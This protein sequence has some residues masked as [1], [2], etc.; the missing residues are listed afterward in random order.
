MEKEVYKTIVQPKEETLNYLRGWKRP[1]HA[2]ILFETKEW[3]LSHD[4]E[5][6]LGTGLMT[7]NAES[8]P[9]IEHHLDIYLKK[10]FRILD[11]GNFPKFSDQDP[12]RAAKAMHY[13]QGAGINPWDALERA[14]KQ[15]MAS[16]INWSERASA[17]EDEINVLKKKLEE[18]QNKLAVK[19]QLAKRTEQS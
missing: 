16:E 4:G 9:E 2:Y 12:R 5:R 8:R 10:G 14:V 11:Y 3:H 7:L 1:G 19:Q 18:E 6:R 13:S 17:Y 15:K